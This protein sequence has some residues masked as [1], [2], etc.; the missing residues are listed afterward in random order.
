MTA[1]NLSK[2]R[3]LSG[4]QC[5]LK[6]WYDVHEPGL[7]LPPD[8]AREALFAAGHAVGELARERWPGGVLV[9]VEPWQREDA[10]RATR[11]LMTD[12]S[13]PAIYEAG[14]V[15]RNVLTRVDI[16]VRAPDGAW[17]L[18]EVKRSTRVKEVFAFDVA[19]QYWILRGAGVP[20]R[21]AG[22]LLL[23]RTYVYAG[24]EYELEALFRFEDLTEQCEERHAELGERVASM[25]AMLSAGQAPLVAIGDQCHAP[26]ECDYFAHCA[27]DVVRPANP[28]ELLP[29]LREARRGWL[30]DAGIKAVEDIPSDYE[31]TPSQERVRQCIVSGEP[32]VSPDLDGALADARWPLYFLDFEAANLDLPRQ[33]GMRPFEALP[34]QFSCHV[35]VSPGSLLQHVEFLSDSTDD[36]RELIAQALLDALGDD[37]SIVVYSDY[38]RRTINALAAWLPDL[39][40]QLRLLGDRLLDLL[41]IIRGHY[42]HPSFRGSYSIKK[43]LPA[44]TGMSYEGMAIADGE[45][46]GRGWLEMLDSR[47]PARREELRSALLDYCSQDSL[48]MVRVWERLGD[49]A[50][51]AGR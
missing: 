37:G 42:C 2:T 7:R 41:Q 19:I 47:E 49:T 12:L 31:L 28:I 13:V 20:L 45:A 32:W 14:F 8:A 29:G 24:G 18:V 4:R 44:M 25:Q 43:V 9:D 46:A 36:P 6:L 1:T 22:L 10:E 23:D 3:F 26:Y 16:L 38:E 34:F 40:S 11:A 35:Q 33:V 17:D 50:K 48:A 51:G 21:S 5:P 39:A 15:H 27:R 30:D